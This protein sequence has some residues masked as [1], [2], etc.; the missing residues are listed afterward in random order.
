[1]GRHTVRQRH[2]TIQVSKLREAALKEAD[3]RTN[4]PSFDREHKQPQP[5]EDFDR[6]NGVARY[7]GGQVE[8]IG[9]GSGGLR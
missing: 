6:T 3:G 2:G 9:N 4:M 1:M 7:H 5:P 8:H